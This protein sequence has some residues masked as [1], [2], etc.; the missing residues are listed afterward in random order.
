MS[1]RCVDIFWASVRYLA[2]RLAEPA[3]WRGIV[4]I[5]TGGITKIFSAPSPDVAA[6]MAVDAASIGMIL[7]GLIGLLLPEKFDKK[8]D[9]E[10]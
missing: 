3:S 4:W 7:A 9:G 2:S 1:R 8:K 10:Q 5:A 6:Q